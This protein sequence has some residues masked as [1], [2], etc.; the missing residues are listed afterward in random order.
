[1][2]QEWRAELSADHGARVRRYT[3]SLATQTATIRV[4]RTTHDLL[5]AQA[6]RRGLSVAALLANMAHERELTA[7]W[8]SEREAAR[9]DAR[10][11]TAHLEDQSWDAL[12]ADGLE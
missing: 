8:E 3:P 2:S 11:P 4:S 7:I 10:N 6:Q 1:M 9:V 12:A 5:A